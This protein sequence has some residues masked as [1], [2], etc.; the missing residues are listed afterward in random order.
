M[1]SEDENCRIV[2]DHCHYTGNIMD[3]LIVSVT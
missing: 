1:L 2:R 3:L